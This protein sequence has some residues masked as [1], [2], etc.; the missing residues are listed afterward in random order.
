VR[1]LL[2]RVTEA[3]VNLEGETL[4]AIGPGLVVLV[5]AEKGDDEGQA[6]Y[7]ARKIANMRVFADAD[8]KTNLSILDVGGEALVISQ[9]TLSAEWRKGN[10][11]GFSAAA[12]P[13][14]AEQLYEYFCRQLGD[15]GVPV[16]T[17]KFRSHMAVH[18][19]ND[20]PMTIWMD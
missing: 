15:E 17:G 16:K 11:P 7:F 12:D 9:F 20:G 10:R 14:V 4:A 1:A 3:S 2:Q 8:G 13:E 19:V 6:D 5:C 18:L